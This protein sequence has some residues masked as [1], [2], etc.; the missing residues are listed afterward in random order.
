MKKHIFMTLLTLLATSS[1]SFGDSSTNIAKVTK[2]Q[3][4]GVFTPESILPAGVDNSLS[5]NP[6]T[7]ESGPARKGTVAA[8]LNNIAVLNTLLSAEIASNDR[9]KLQETIKAIVAL[10]PSLRVVGVFDLFTPEEWLSSQTQPGR[11]LTAVLYLE[12]YPQSM[13]PAIKQKLSRI[14]NKT[15][16]KILSDAIEKVLKK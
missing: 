4:T 11:V 9:I 7:G 12:Q 14:K 8:T 3:T 13:T 10:L 15:K 6:Y 16:V 5:S 2:D 1:L